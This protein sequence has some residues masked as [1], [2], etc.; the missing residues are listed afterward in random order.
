[1][2]FSS[3]FFSSVFVFWNWDF[4]LGER[5]RSREG[6]GAR[7]ARISREAPEKT[8]Q[9]THPPVSTHQANH[10]RI[11]QLRATTAALDAQIRETLQLLADTRK[12]VIDTPATVFSEHTNPINYGDLLRYARRIAKF[13]R[14]PSYRDA[15]IKE[16]EDGEVGSPIDAGTGTGTGGS[17]PLVAAS[18][19]GININGAV[20]NGAGGDTS[21][22][23]SRVQS[24]SVADGVGGA[25]SA[26]AT[27]TD[28]KAKATDLPADWVAFLN[29]VPQADALFAPWPKEEQIKSGALA[30]LEMLR[31]QGRRIEDVDL[32]AEERE[33][34]ERKVREVEEEERRKGE[35]EREMVRRREVAM[36]QAGQGTRGAERPKVFMGLDLLDEDDD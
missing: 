14:A 2:S 13:T 17:T 10:L 25:G 33:E 4:G 5:E 18:A 34:E 16:R 8:T 9:L 26:L 30:V 23:Q 1:V 6:K 21:Q 3:F 27:P 32:E 7:G 28:G 11:Q 35:E 15:S 24:M 31:G 19:Q 12:E 20:V 22:S 36:T 29:P